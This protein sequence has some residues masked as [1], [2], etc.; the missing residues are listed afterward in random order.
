MPRTKSALEFQFISRG[1]HARPTAK[2]DNH[3]TACLQ[4]GSEWAHLGSN[5]GPPACEVPPMFAAFRRV[6]P[7]RL[8]ERV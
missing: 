8:L 7:N 6:T 3:E 1:N 2:P 5:Q 4:R